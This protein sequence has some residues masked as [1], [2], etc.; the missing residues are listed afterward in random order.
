M[1]TPDEPGTLE[2]LQALEDKFNRLVKALQE[3][4][5]T[6]GGTNY[7]VL[8]SAGLARPEPKWPRSGK[9]DVII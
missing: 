2:R 3:D 9:R 1:S 4:A 8:K 5:D 6:Y 7:R